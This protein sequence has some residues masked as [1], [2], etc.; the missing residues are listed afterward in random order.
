MP[1]KR[2]SNGS[3]ELLFGKLVEEY[4]R[5]KG[6]HSVVGDQAIPQAE[7]AYN[8]SRNRSTR[9][10]PFRSCMAGHLTVC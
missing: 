9:K 10:S 4:C 5:G 2:G 7:L 1:T 8:S 3:R 6:K